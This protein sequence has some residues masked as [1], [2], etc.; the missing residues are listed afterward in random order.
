MTTMVMHRFPLL[1][2][3]LWCQPHRDIP[4]YPVPCNARA[5]GT[6]LFTIQELSASTER[7]LLRKFYTS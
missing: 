2:L 3:P 5:Q 1:V 7:D 4:Q 6:L